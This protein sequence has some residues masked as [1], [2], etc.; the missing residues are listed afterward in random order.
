MRWT[1]DFILDGSLWVALAVYALTFISYLNFH[2]YPDQN[3]L[4]FVFYATIF[5][6]NFVKYWAPFKNQ[7]GGK[8]FLTFSDRTTMRPRLKLIVVM[9]VIA[10]LLSGYYFFQMQSVIAQLFI[11]I[12]LIFTYFYT[13]TVGEHSLRSKAG[14]KIFVIAL[15]WVMVTVGLPYLTK[16]CRYLPEVIIEMAQRFFFVVAITLPFEIRDLATDQSDLKTV[17][18][19]FGVRNTKFIGTVL[20]FA[21]IALEGCKREGYANLNLSLLVGGMVLLLLWGASKNQWKYYSSFIV[22]GIPI[23]WL[24]LIH[25]FF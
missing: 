19:S 9:S 20:M 10:A 25:F 13:V 15:C 17:P 24:V 8:A 2:Q 14:I 21:F 4:G 22:E 23:Y 6:Y 5:G 3:T 1:F 16:G 18:Q 12:P 11:V 7:G